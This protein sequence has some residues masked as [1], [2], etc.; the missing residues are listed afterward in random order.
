MA[1]VTIS[2]RVD[3]DLRARMA[4]AAQQTG[5]DVSDLARMGMNLITEKIKRDGG[6]HLPVRL[7]DEEQEQR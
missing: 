3:E 7:E 4:E 1:K 6:L 2:T 5:I